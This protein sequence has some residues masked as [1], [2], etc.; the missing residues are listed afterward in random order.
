MQAQCP[1]RSRFIIYFV[2]LFGVLLPMLAIGLVLENGFV[3]GSPFNPIP[4]MVY[5]LMVGAV[6][7]A[8][9]FV[10]VALWRGETA[11]PRQLGWLHT[12]SIG[13]ALAYALHFAPLM[14]VAIALLMV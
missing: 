13:V 3:R 11:L 6:P 5:I 9:A 4:N 14:P 2:A 7:V 12:F 1:P 10:A 8:N